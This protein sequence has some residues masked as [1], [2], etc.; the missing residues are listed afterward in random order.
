MTVAV[1]SLFVHMPFNLSILEPS[2]QLT[3]GLQG[4][5]PCSNI[6]LPLLFQSMFFLV[7]KILLKACPKSFLPEETGEREANM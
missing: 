6:L 2:T 4:S 7:S 1:P 3:Q 5:H